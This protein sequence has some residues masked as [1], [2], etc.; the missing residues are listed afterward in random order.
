MKNTDFNIPYQSAL[1]KVRKAK[2]SYRYDFK[3]NL[4]TEAI[5]LY[6]DALEITLKTKVEPHIINDIYHHVANLFIEWGDS[7]LKQRELT[8]AQDFKT[9]TDKAKEKYKFGLDFL[10]TSKHPDKA[11]TQLKQVIHQKWD[12]LTSPLP[13]NN[14]TASYIPSIAEAIE[15]DISMFTNKNE[16]SS[17]GKKRNHETMNNNNYPTELDSYTAD[18]LIEEKIKLMRLVEYTKKRP[19]WAIKNDIKRLHNELRSLEAKTNGSR[20]SYN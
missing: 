18:K 4:L 5:S 11:I 8:N 20:N 16:K 1:K 9:T 6:R 2:E 7:L 10:N 17:T 13:S 3:Y 19:S 15:Y 14:S 12:S